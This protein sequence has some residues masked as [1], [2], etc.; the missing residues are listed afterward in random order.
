MKLAPALFLL[1]SAAA[2]AA[3]TVEEK[4]ESALRDGIPQAAIAPLEE[5]LRKAP[6]AEK[7]RLGLLLA[8]AQLAAGRPADALKTLDSS[9]DRNS[10]EAIADNTASHTGRYLKEVLG[11]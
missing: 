1:L 10:A 2:L 5:A 4:A 8:R 9:A 7:N 11:R 6:A 3:A